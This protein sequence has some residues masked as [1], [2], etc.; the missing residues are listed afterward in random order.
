MFGERGHLEDVCRAEGLLHLV[1]LVGADGVEVHTV[2][3]L[4][5]N[6]GAV[7]ALQ[8]LVRALEVVQQV[9]VVLAILEVVE[10]RVLCPDALGT[11][12]HWCLIGGILNAKSKVF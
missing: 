1:E 11:H 9:L 10:L 5:Q 2:Q 6:L 4:R 8:V 12:I 7:E 3:L